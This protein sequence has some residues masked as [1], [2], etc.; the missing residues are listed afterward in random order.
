MRE[1]YTRAEIEVILFSGE[2]DII[3]TS[4]EEADM[5]ESSSGN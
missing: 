3:C 5:E 2:E 1:Q 4:N